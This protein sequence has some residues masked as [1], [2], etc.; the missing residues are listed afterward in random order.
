METAISDSRCFLFL[1]S[2]E[3]A[4]SAWVQR[5]VAFWCSNRERSNFY[6]LLTGGGIAWS[7][8]NDDF[9][10]NLTTAVPPLL[11]RYFHDE[12]VWLDL[13]QVAREQTDAGQLNSVALEE[14]ARAIAALLYGVGKEQVR[15]DEKRQGLFVT[16]SALRNELRIRE[17]QLKEQSARLEQQDVQLQQQTLR[18]EELA[19]FDREAEV[20]GGVFISYSHADRDVVDALTA[21]FEIDKIN[22]WRDEKDLLVGDVIDKAISRGIQQSILFLVVLTPS[23]VKSRWVERELDEAAHEETEGSK[24]VLPVL[25]KGLGHDK[26]PYRLRRKLYVDVSEYTFDSGYAKLVQSIKQHLK[27]VHLRDQAP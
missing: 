12:P 22:Y 20:K 9:D 21:R 19:A 4:R 24:I 23:S 15:E 27:N 5:E 8:Q 3:A 10:W 6:I 14:S 25:A 11:S 2:P 1:A 7:P 26:I 16:R 13:R 17:A 18:L